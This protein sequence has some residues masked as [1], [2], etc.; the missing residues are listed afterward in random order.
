M[1][2][3]DA[4]FSNNI[5]QLRKYLANGD[6]NVKNERGMSLIHYAI[7]FNNSEIFDLLLENFININIQDKYGDTPI[8]YCVVNNRIGFLKS[9]IRNGAD[10]T[11][12]NNDGQAPLF[13]ACSLG[14][15]EM[16]YLLLESTNFNLHEKDNKEETVFFT[17][18]RSRNLDLLNKIVLDDNIV[19]IPNYIGETPLHIASKSGDIRV[20]DYLIK[21]HVFI[22]SKNKSGETPLFYAV[23]QQN[24]EI[25][26]VLLKNGALLDC[27]STFGDTIYDLIPTYE[28]SSFINEKC[29]KYKTY[30]YRSNYPLHYAIIIENYDLVKKYAV[31]RN[32]S[33]LDNFGFTPLE[34]A[35]KLNNDRIIKILNE[36]FLDN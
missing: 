1:N 17:L 34:L 35:R 31:I 15:E 6:V 33:R 11:I 25:I 32:V 9:L 10:V 24:K 2:V 4:V 23:N 18:I 28:L 5:S 21:N 26:D 20:V 7:I 13:K 19:D 30:L 14:R 12:K 3:F 27:K 36:S 8:H 16:I 29:E 22:N